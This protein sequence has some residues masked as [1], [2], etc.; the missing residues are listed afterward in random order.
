MPSDQP[1]G[2]GL[3]YVPPVGLVVIGELSGDLLNTM[4]TKELCPSSPCSPLI[5]TTDQSPVT[6]FYTERTAIHISFTVPVLCH[7]APFR[8]YVGL[9]GFVPVKLL[10]S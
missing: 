5:F 8:G 4:E 1:E 3:L 7:V 9:P 10:N 2:I 6:P